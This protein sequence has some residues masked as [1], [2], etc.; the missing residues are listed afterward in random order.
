MIAENEFSLRYAL[1]A[2]LPP[3][4]FLFFKLLINGCQI[5]SWGVDTTQCSAGTVAKALYQPSQALLD[6][7]TASKPSVLGIESRYFHFAPGYGIKSAAEDGGLIEVRVFRCIG[8]R[9]AAPMLAEYRG[10]EH[11]GIA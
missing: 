2:P 3:S 8:R 11:Y 6:A 1:E 4:P 9:R 7:W 5:V 10:Q